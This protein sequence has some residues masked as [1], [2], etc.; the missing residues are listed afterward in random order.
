MLV[1]VLRD[2]ARWGSGIR[3]KAVSVVN[4]GANPLPSKSLSSAPSGRKCPLTALDRRSIDNLLSYAAT[5][6]VAALYASSADA[7]GCAGISNQSSTFADCDWAAADAMADT[8]TT[9]L[10]RQRTRN[11]ENP[12]AI[13]TL[14]N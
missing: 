13:V 1:G 14:D 8:A 2:A 10:R 9:R 6:P 7:T 4:C 12:S 3:T 5:I 11:P